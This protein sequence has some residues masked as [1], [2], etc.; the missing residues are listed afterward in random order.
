MIGVFYARVLIPRFTDMI[1]KT[2]K[3]WS[4]FCK[5][6]QYEIIISSQKDHFHR[7]R[8]VRLRDYLK[9]YQV[10]DFLNVC[11]IGST[12]QFKFKYFMTSLI[13]LI[14]NNGCINVIRFSWK[15]FLA[16]LSFELFLKWYHFKYEYHFYFH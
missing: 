11:I 10:V 9:H 1:T 4:N 8:T 12:V 3:L 5:L 2:Y 6:P 16:D 15:I 13:Y 7:L 14:E